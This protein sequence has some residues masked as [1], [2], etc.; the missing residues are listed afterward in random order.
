V[1]E[2]AFHINPVLHDSEGENEE[3]KGVMAPLAAQ[4]PG[5][6]LADINRP[7]GHSA[8]HG[9][10]A[11]PACPVRAG[12]AGWTQRRRKAHHPQNLQR[13][14]ARPGRRAAS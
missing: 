13:R 4:H 12:E 9:G 2:A 3:I 10:S 1:T 11:R 5:C 14:A 6:V 8:T 7:A